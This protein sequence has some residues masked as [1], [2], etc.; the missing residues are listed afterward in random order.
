MNSINSCSR[1]VAAALCAVVLVACDAIKDVRDKPS[2][3]F[4][5]QK[6]VITG[7]IHGLG[8]ARTISL[9]FDGRQDCFAPHPSNSSI[10]I[11][12]D[13]QFFGIQDQQISTFSFGSTDVGTPYFVRVVKNPLTKICTVDNGVAANGQPATDFDPDFDLDAPQNAGANPRVVGDGK[14]N[15]VVTCVTDVSVPRYD[16]TVNTGPLSVQSGALVTLKTEDGTW[17]KDASGQA[18]VTFDD[19]LFN[20]GLSSLPKMQYQLTATY[21]GTAGGAAVTSYCSFLA[22]TSGP[23]VITAGGTNLNA[24]GND[25]VI[26]THNTTVSVEKCTVGVRLT[27]QYS[28]TPAVTNLP[29]GGMQLGLRNHLT[30]AI[31]QALVVPQ[32]TAF[33]SA[34]TYQFANE[35][36]ANER[37]MYEVVITQH[38]AGMHCV[39]G[40]SVG[41]FTREATLGVSATT[42]GTVYGATGSAVLTLNPAIPEWWMTTPRPVFCRLIPTDPSKLL[43]G[44][45]QRDRA[46]RNQTNI[47]NNTNPAR[48]REFLTFFNDGTFMFGINFPDATVTTCEALFHV[49]TE[50]DATINFPNC[51][52]NSP[53]RLPGQAGPNFAAVVSNWN[54]NSGVDHGFYAYDPVADT[55]V[56]TV[57]NASNIFPN[58]FGI[59]GMPGYLPVFEPGTTNQTVRGTVTATNVTKTNATVDEGGKISL[60]FTGA[61]P[62][63]RPGSAVATYTGAAQ[64]TTWKMTEPLAINGEVTGAWVTAD[65]LRMF[66][67]NKNEYFG[68]HMSMDGL[69]TLQDACYL[70]D[71]LS[72]QTSGRLNRH[73]GG[74]ATCLPGGSARFRDIPF[75]LLGQ[76]TT[77]PRRPALYRG[78]FPGSANPLDNRPS[79]PSL[80]EVTPGVGGADELTVQATINGTPTDQAPITFVRE[81]ANPAIP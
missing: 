48:A 30:G 16:L 19:V 1:L 6:G 65:H 55:I 49:P 72:T 20:S 43:T 31:E 58:Y 34:T 5:T 36:T 8:A 37:S 40:G 51:T 57:T 59:N 39:V 18:S 2:V 14:P 78:G 22:V 4:P 79:P 46:A 17:Q 23:D 10:L 33:S 7:E 64:T 3:D 45:Y 60:K 25:V 13:C 9:S 42:G 11:P 61:R 24:A 26:P 41:A 35:V 68:F 74:S 75:P 73:S 63:P 44:T 56:F 62:N 38:P 81:R 28:G 67:Y 50:L 27:V 69:A 32:G 53:V 70:V 76:A 80:F 47:D 12:A 21:N 77:M 52:G 71:D 66:A 54:T 29:T 15:P